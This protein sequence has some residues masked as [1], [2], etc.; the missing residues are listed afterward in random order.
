MTTHYLPEAEACDRVGIIDRGKL[1]AIGA[2]GALIR[3]HGS[4]DDATLEDVFIR[5]T[6]H[7]LRDEAATAH[8]M[9]VNFGKRGGE[10][11]R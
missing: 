5:L 4:G 1:V 11:T 7:R 3:Q 8:D 10:H 2:P 6:G 9:V